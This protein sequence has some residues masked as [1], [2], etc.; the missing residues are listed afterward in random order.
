[1]LLTEPPDAE[2][3]L[4][5]MCGKDNE[6]EGI[7]EIPARP[8]P[9]PGVI[10]ALPTEIL[11]GKV[12]EF[13]AICESLPDAD[14]P[15]G[16][17]RLPSEVLFTIF[18]A[19]AS[20][21][22]SD[23]DELWDAKLISTDW[24]VVNLVCRHWH[25][26]A[27]AFPILWR[28]V[29][30]GSSV[31]WLRLCLDRSASAPLDLRL[32]DRTTVF[33]AA[34][35]LV[36]HAGRIRSL[37]VPRD[38]AADSL[39]ALSS[40]FMVGLPALK[41]LYLDASRR[42]A[43]FAGKCLYDVFRLEDKSEPLFP[44]LHTLH[45]NSLYL[46][47][48]ASLLRGLRS[49]E[50]IESQPQGPHLKTRPTFDEFLDALDA[51]HPTLEHL[52]LCNSFPFCLCDDCGGGGTAGRTVALPKLQT[53]SVLCPPQADT[54]ELSTGK[55]TSCRHFLSYLRLPER[56][57]T[58]VSTA[59]SH[60]DHKTF[61]QYLPADPAC[62]PVLAAAVSASFRGAWQFEAHTPCACQ[63]RR[64][65]DV[66]AQ[67]TYDNGHA[68][69]EEA[70]KAIQ[71]GGRC[72]GML[73]MDILDMERCP[74]D[75]AEE[76][77]A[78][79]EFAELF[80]HA[81]L[82]Q[83]EVYHG[84]SAAGFGH[85][86]GTLRGL[87]VLFF[88]GSSLVTREHIR[89]FLF[90]LSAPYTLGHGYGHTGKSTKGRKEGKGKEKEVANVD[91]PLPELGAL[92]LHC[93]CWYGGFAQDLATCLRSRA[94]NGARKLAH[95]HVVLLSAKGSNRGKLNKKRTQQLRRMT[96]LTE[97]PVEVDVILAN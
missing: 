35:L 9:D 45:L 20:P 94:E 91:V 97:T 44:S 13:V 7:Y 48:R 68:K 30:V 14:K 50:L 78:A 36:T 65:R 95:L 22:E 80:A 5:V 29:D 2:D 56:M 4:A 71:S 82:R 85:L 28:A 37:R 3:V 16:I 89:D 32:Y 38:V 77:E 58:T 31:E 18:K 96:E 67:L 66:H 93:V 11:F 8:P 1:M 87:A 64:L 63:G 88:Q 86:F 90:A 25:T 27:C 34:A 41:E 55:T 75:V 39:H 17:N 69:G 51:C 24:L 60:R 49:L 74:L 26:V 81:P 19:L 43:P 21:A 54:I 61:C 79:R 73:T 62:L 53:L 33:Q 12:N 10:N 72:A 52:T 70:G 23:E 46:P 40:L 59:R 57:W 84:L 83:L 42:D 92:C 15:Q 76:D 47:P 6:F